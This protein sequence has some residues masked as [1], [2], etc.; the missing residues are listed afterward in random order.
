MISSQSFIDRFFR[1]RLYRYF[2]LKRLIEE[3][4]YLVY[5]RHIGIRLYRIS[6]V[7]RTCGYFA[8][9]SHQ[10]AN[11]NAECVARNCIGLVLFFMFYKCA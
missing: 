3:R 4:T 6:H 9:V 7:P 1:N 8:G 10:H 11:R 5:R 2:G